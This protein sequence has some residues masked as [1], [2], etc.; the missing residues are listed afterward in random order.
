MTGL[1]LLQARR[2][3]ETDRF[4]DQA[5]AFDG[6]NILALWVSSAAKTAQGLFDPAIARLERA[7]ALSNRSP[8]IHG[9]LGWTLAAAGRAKEASGVLEALRARPAP[10]TTVLPEA[11]MLASLGDWEGAWQVLDRAYDEKQLLVP[12]TGLPGFDPL[13]GDPRFAAL[14]ER[15][16][17]PSA[18]GHSS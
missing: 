7:L 12:F 13:R 8:F 17:L 4:L 16:G 11:W 18:G 2:P 15:L 1:C 10:A 14:Q 3:E 5:L 9:A 6:D